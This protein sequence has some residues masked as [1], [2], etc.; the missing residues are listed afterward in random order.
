MYLFKERRI[1]G[2]VRHHLRGGGQVRAVAE[3]R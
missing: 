1:G 3:E 2:V